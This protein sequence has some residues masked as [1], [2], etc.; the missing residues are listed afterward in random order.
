MRTVEENRIYQAAWREK[1]KDRLKARAAR[2]YLKN[3]ERIGVRV[4]E[5]Q[6]S[7]KEYLAAYRAAWR[8]KNK[9]HLAAYR[10]ASKE[11]RAAY[12]AV[13]NEENRGRIA[14]RHAQYREKNKEHIAAQK[15]QSNC[16]VQNQFYDRY[17]LPMKGHE[18]GVCTCCKGADLVMFGTISHIDGSGK[19]HREATNGNTYRMMKEA[20]AHYDPT[21]FAAECCNCNDGA[22]RN[23]GICPHKV[24]EG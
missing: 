1:N 14:A 16:I 5:W 21:R 23:G 18:H 7:H 19:Q 3:K 6:G 10:E 24:K 12:A 2:Y 4:S 20:V 8:E 15:A 9:E 17:G 13:Y 11:R 22:R